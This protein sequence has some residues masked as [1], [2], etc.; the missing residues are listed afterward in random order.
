MW[1]VLGKI[2]GAI[3]A[4]FLDYIYGKI[5][6]YVALQKK[7]STEKA[8]LKARV[9]KQVEQLKKAETKEDIDA[10]ADAMLDDF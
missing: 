4:F 1:A 6:D 8:E 5:T 9:Q 10:A 3:L 7:K 2:G